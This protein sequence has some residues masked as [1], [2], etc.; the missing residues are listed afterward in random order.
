MAV[1]NN[2][3]NCIWKKKVFKYKHTSHGHLQYKILNLK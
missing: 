2:I 1:F 3:N